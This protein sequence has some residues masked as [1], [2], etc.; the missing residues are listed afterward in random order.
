MV[1]RDPWTAIF[2]LIQVSRSLI[3]IW[4]VDINFAAMRLSPMV[5]KSKR[6]FV[7]SPLTVM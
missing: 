4:N 3:G 2:K 6:T 5:T 7:L 1:E